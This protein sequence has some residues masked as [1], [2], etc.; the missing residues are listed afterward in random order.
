MRSL[1]LVV[2]DEIDLA[3][4][5][6]CQLR[7]DGC[8][9]IVAYNGN[10]ALARAVANPVPHAILLDVVLP[11]LSGLDV[12]RRL[13]AQERTRDVPILMCS[14]RA[15]EVDRIVGLEVGADDY[16]VKPYSVREVSLRVRN[17]I[18]RTQTNGNTSELRRFGPM[19]IDEP[20]HRVW[21]S[22]RPVTLTVLEFRLLHYFLEHVGQVLTREQILRD[23]WGVA[24]AATGRAVDTHVK[25]LRDK[26]GSDASEYIETL[27]GLGY[28]LRLETEPARS[29]AS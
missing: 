26:L 20:G 29:I 12:C 10:D 25:R 4:T 21:I 17:F 8:D 2:E 3:T 1:V 7:L 15:Q 19:V 28:R 22:G 9:S 18:R 13:R 27:R 14:A 11:D 5:V 16:L 23:V 6:A 24:D